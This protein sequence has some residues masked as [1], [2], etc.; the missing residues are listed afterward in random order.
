MRSHIDEL[1][2][3]YVEVFDLFAAHLPMLILEKCFWVVTNDAYEPYLANPMARLG[4]RWPDDPVCFDLLHWSLQFNNY[5]GTKQ[6][7]P[8]RPM[9]KIESKTPIQEKLEK[10]RSDR[11]ISK[12]GTMV[13]KMTGV[14]IEPAASSTDDPEPAASS[15][16][17]RSKQGREASK[18]N[19][20]K[21]G[22]RGKNRK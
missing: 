2:S 18:D 16:D 13:A 19:Q 6:V 10:R 3:H 21:K 12:F 14:T 1:K 17:D 7:T 11:L 15:T 4:I 9:M 8:G 22:S 5:I 20:K